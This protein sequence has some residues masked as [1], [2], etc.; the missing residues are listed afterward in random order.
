MSVRLELKLRGCVSAWAAS[1]CVLVAVAAACKS[2][3]VVYRLPPRHVE[4]PADSGVSG[5]G[6]SAGEAGSAGTGVGGG[7]VDVG[8][9]GI[10]GQAGTGGNAG[11]EAGA[12]A[13]AGAGGGGGAAGTDSGRDEICTGGRDG[14][15]LAESIVRIIGESVT[16]QCET[17]E[18]C[19]T[20]PAFPRCNLGERRCEPCPDLA[21]K[22]YDF[23]VCLVEARDRCCDSPE[24]PVDCVYRRCIPGCEA[25]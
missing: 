20:S 13:G 2:D 17:D 22:I 10:N 21:A 23:T 7:S 5:S 1:A 18:N 14:V 8:G 19:N 12:G 6:G 3:A 16:L 24:S 15:A 4:P 25:Q 11:A 9:A